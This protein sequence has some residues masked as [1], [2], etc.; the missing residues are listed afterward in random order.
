M[1][2]PGAAED[3]LFVYG[4]SGN[5]VLGDLFALDLISMQWRELGPFAEPPPK[6]Y[7]HSLA[8][9]AGSLWLYG[10]TNEANVP[11]R[12]LY[13]L[14]LPSV[15]QEGRPRIKCAVLA[16]ECICLMPLLLK[17]S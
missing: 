9:H 8:A 10:G 16:L 4:G 15:M 6:L 11:C 3:M 1:Y 14:S 17:G 12:R 13:R 7:G 2:C 5:F